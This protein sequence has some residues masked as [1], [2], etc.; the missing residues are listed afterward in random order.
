M[1]FKS[2]YKEV[3]LSCAAV[4]RSRRKEPKTPKALYGEYRK[5]DRWGKKSRQCPVKGCV[6]LLPAGAKVGDHLCGGVD[7][8]PHPW[9]KMG[10]FR[11]RG[12]L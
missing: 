12:E 5:R 3:G 11:V 9:R 6:K 7:K 8:K 1:A 2:V 10:Q 4:L